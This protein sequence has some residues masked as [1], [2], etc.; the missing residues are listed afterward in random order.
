MVPILLSGTKLT[1]S[2]SVG[3]APLAVDFK[4]VPFPEGTAVKEYRWDFDGDGVDDIFVAQ[5]LYAYPDELGQE[6]GFEPDSALSRFYLS[7]DG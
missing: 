6:P 4:A 2:K 7:S 5:Q 3:A 1:A